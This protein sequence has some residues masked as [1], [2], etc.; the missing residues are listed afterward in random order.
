M[1]IAKV[2][3]CNIAPNINPLSYGVSN[4]YEYRKEGLYRTELGQVHDYKARVLNNV[5]CSGNQICH[6]HAGMFA[7]A[8]DLAKLF[9]ALLRG[10]I[11][12]VGVLKK[13][14]KKHMGTYCGE[15]FT[16]YLGELCYSKN[17]CAKNSEVAS[18]FSNYSIGCGG[19][20]GNH[21]CIDTVNEVYTILLSNRC[22][23]RATYDD[24]DC[25]KVITA[26]FA[27]DREHLSNKLALLAL[28]QKFIDS[29]RENLR[30]LQ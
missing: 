15:K 8:D 30:I 10:E 12:D 24:K 28:E 3:G 6:G 17:P 22:N 9:T 1:I 11:V 7:S 20:T 14:A 25:G 26:S 19:Y 27:Y 4:D 29:L 23:N 21:I 5:C 16:K 2:Q 18:Y 13:I